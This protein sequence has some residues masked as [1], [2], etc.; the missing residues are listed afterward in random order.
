MKAKIFK[1]LNGFFKKRGYIIK[2]I[3]AV[4]LMNRFYESFRR[5][6]DEAGHEIASLVFSKDRAMQLHAFLSSYFEN[7][8][9]HSKMIVLYRASTDEHLKSYQDVENLFK[10]HPVKFVQEFNFRDQ[11]ISE[12]SD[13]DA[14]KLIL[15]VDDMIF[16]HKFNY[17]LLK[18]INPYETCVAL[19]RGRDMTYSYVLS[20]DLELPEL[21]EL[22]NQLL[23]FSWNEIRGKSDWSYPLGVSGYM[24][25][26]R[27]FLAMTK[28][29]TFKAPNSLEG[30]LQPF[31]P[32]FK[33]RKGIC[34]E[35][36]VSVCVH[37]NLVQDEADNPFLG[38]FTIEQLLQKWNE[39][40][41]IN[42][43]E[44]YGRP[45]T[46]TQEQNYSFIPRS[47]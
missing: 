29:V 31:M 43:S 47:R 45:M 34:T 39:G 7:V 41:Q 37:A 11:L 13:C 17:E 2:E 35:N 30:A 18:Q 24:F 15:Y 44:F 14:K 10:E 26:T 20:K 12:V 32:I 22:E 5:I 33:N 28:N 36:A 23:E 16:T 46:I 4:E 38:E 42:C 1:R 25:S 8:E 6:S 40:Y 27:E 21:T 9:N 19:S 3:P